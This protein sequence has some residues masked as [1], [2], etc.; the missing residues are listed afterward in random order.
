MPVI[1]NDSNKPKISGWNSGLTRARIAGHLFLNGNGMVTTQ[2]ALRLVELLHEVGI[3]GD[4]FN[5]AAYGV[6]LFRN[7]KAS[8]KASWIALRDKERAK[9]VSAVKKKFKVDIDADDFDIADALATIE[10]KVSK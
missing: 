10:S 3:I 8:K 7:L 9:V 4:D 1:W 6:R 5:A 2:P